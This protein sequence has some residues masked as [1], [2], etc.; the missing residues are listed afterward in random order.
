[1]AGRQRRRMHWKTDAGG[2]GQVDNIATVDETN[3]ANVHGL[4]CSIAIEP[5][6]ADANANGTWV[7][8]CIP[9]QDTSRASM[10]FGALETEVAN[11]EVWACGVWVA[12]NQTGFNHDLDIGTSRNC[13]NG[14]RIILTISKEGITAGNVR[15]NTMITYFTT[16]L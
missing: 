14:T 10:S 13:P 11:P 7:L 5:E 16:S 12:T 4:R 15:V 1:M 8:W 6:N 2:I 9:R 3:G